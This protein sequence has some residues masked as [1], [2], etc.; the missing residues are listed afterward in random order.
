[1]EVIGTIL[2]YALVASPVVLAFYYFKK[3]KDAKETE[4]K[5]FFKTKDGK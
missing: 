1:M 4:A 5:T 2:T 3:R